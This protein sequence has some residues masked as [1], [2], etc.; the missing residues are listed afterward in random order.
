[1]PQYILGHQVRYWLVMHGSDSLEPACNTMQEFNIVGVGD[2]DT[3]LQSQDV[4][5]MLKRCYSLQFNQ[6]L[7]CLAAALSLN[8]NYVL[9][10]Q[11][12]THYLGDHFEVGLLWHMTIWHFPTIMNWH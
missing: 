8:G 1:M 5:H 11:Q 2:M 7:H 10:I 12:T 9:C 6:R 4:A 3:L